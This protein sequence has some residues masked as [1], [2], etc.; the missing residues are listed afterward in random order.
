MRLL[1]TLTHS[2]THSVW[3]RY[4]LKD[5]SVDAELR[6]NVDNIFLLVCKFLQSMK[7]TFLAEMLQLLLVYYSDTATALLT[8]V[9]EL[10]SVQYTYS[11][12]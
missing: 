6:S 5:G 3:Q 2:L 9:S 11:T 10:L 8:E 1:N 4:G 7:L 12:Q